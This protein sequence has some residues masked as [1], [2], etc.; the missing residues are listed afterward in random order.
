MILGLVL[1][2]LAAVAGASADEP[3]EIGGDKQLF[4]DE[5]MIASIDGVEFTLNPARRAERVITA[6]EPW[7]ASGL[8]YCTFLRNGEL[9]QMWYHGWCYDEDI[10]G[11]WMS[12]ICYGE[13]TDGIV[14]TKPDLGQAEFDG[15][16]RNN[17]IALGHLGY[18]HGHHVFIDP[19]ASSP[20]ES[21][22]MI[23][24]DF[25]RVRRKGCPGSSVSGAVSADGIRWKSVDTKCGVIMPAG[26]DTQNAAFFDPNLNKYVAYVRKNN[27]RKDTEG[28]SIRP[29]AR[30]IARSES[31]DF[32]KFPRPEIVLAPDDD[33]PGGRWGSGLYNSAAVLYPFA[34]RVYL[35]FPSVMEYATSLT[36]I[37]IATSRDGVRIDRRF[38][39]F[40]VPIHPNA[41]RLGDQIAYTAYMGPGMIRVG[42]ELWQYG[43]ELDVPHDGVWYGRRVPGGIT[44]YV[45][46]LDGFFSLDARATPGTVTTKAFLLRGKT[47]RLNANAS[48]APAVRREANSEE[49]ASG[50]ETY[51]SSLVVEVLGQD[52]QV[53]AAS[54]PIHGDGVALA[55]VWRERK[56]LVELIDRSVQ[57]RFTLKR[58]KLYAFQVVCGG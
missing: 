23:F 10:E 55:P 42:D 27:Y 7:E 48:L 57:L 1:P 47:L 51:L 22:K 13:S 35:F 21:Y 46:R 19:N 9:F 41:R 30:C 17:I 14:W 32:Q 45:Q 56:D 4:I 54:E 8:G 5:D 6:T 18:A 49:T 25:Y 58:A 36:A 39:E 12:R 3:R 38:R 53:L 24:G 26:T 43:V 50:S 16:R 11:H 34:P 44:R 15:A 31:A 37:Q 29:A 33:D 2:W 40:Y 52:G 28:N 20:E